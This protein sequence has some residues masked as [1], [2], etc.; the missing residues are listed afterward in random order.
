MFPAP[1]V[2]ARGGRHCEDERARVGL[3]GG[4]HQLFYWLSI[5]ARCKP[6]PFP[7]LPYS[8]LFLAAVN[9]VGEIWSIPVFSML[10]GCWP[11]GPDAI[12]GEVPLWNLQLLSASLLTKRRGR[13]ATGGR[14]S[15]PPFVGISVD[16]DPMRWIERG[17]ESVFAQGWG[18]R[19]GVFEKLSAGNPKFGPGH[20]GFMAPAAKLPLMLFSQSYI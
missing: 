10:F 3:V 2:L 5:A 4:F 16:Q 9:R 20:C 15:E 19:R 18:R 14:R 12:G 6:P 11:R 1:P 13:S 17:G 8:Q 7:V